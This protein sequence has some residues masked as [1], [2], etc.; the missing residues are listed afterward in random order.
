MFIIPGS[1]YAIKKTKDKGWG[2]FAAQD[3]EAGTIIGD[4]LGTIMPRDGSDEREKGLYDMAGGLKYEILANPRKRGVHLINHSCANNCETYPYKGHILYFTLRKIFRGEELTANYSLYAP[5]EDVPCRLHACYCGSKFC[6]GT[7]HDDWR[8]F[9]EW[10]AF[11]KKQFGPWYR[12]IPGAYG[13]ELLPLLRYPESIKKD[14][15]KLFN[16]FGSEKKPAARYQDSKLPSITV[17]RQRIRTTGRRIAF[18]KL[19]ITI[20]GVKNSILLVERK[21]S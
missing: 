3:I 15:P 7:M 16:I 10:E 6:N 2:I 20:D 18:P 14:Y 11:L 13:S 4:Y 17:M 19:G 5:E 9:E 8:H 1:Q 12:K 21:G